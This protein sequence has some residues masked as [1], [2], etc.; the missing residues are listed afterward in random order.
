M[1]HKTNVDDIARNSA[2]RK[3]QRL[4]CLVAAALAAMLFY[5]VLLKLD[6][7]SS[8]AVS[9]FIG[10][11]DHLASVVL[12]AAA[13]YFFV[14]AAGILSVMRKERRASGKRSGSRRTPAPPTPAEERREPAPA[15]PP[16]SK[17][18]SSFFTEWETL[19]ESDSFDIDILPD[20]GSATGQDIIRGAPA[21][22]EPERKSPKVRFG[23]QDERDA[24][25]KMDRKCA[26][27]VYLIREEGGALEG[28]EDGTGVFHVW[29]VEECLSGKLLT[30]SVIHACFEISGLNRAGKKARVRRD[31]P[32]VLREVQRG[33]YELVKMGKITV[34]P[35]ME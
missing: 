3:A 29:P 35:A 30:Y 6:I 1:E 5:A 11:L 25:D 26:G 22:R 12:K 34:S 31:E 23:F 27:T 8:R 20:E 21:V 16:A 32:A 24:L 17:D 4:Y 15:E 13:A 33:V 7:L 14:E 19:A 10:N 9:G 28:E 2:P 18:R